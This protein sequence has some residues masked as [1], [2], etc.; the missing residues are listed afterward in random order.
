MR[1]VRVLFELDAKCSLGNSPGR[2]TFQF[3]GE[4]NNASI[5]WINYQV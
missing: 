2:E 4:F 5:P 3:S 1:A